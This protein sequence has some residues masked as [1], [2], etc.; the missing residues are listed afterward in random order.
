MISLRGTK[1]IDFLGS[2]ENRGKICFWLKKNK[3]GMASGASRRL[4]IVEK[5]ANRKSARKRVD[6]GESLGAKEE[7]DFFS[8]A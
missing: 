8:K 3:K 4:E 2:A 7:V 5:Y 6:K 1:G